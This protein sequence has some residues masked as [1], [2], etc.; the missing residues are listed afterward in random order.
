MVGDWNVVQDYEIDTCNYKSNNNLKAYKKIHDMKES[1]DLVDIWRSLNPDKT[2]YTWRGPGLKQSR[3]DY[4][5]IST[6]F[7]V[8]VKN[9]DIDISYRSDHSPVSLV[10][11][12]YNQKREG[13]PGNLIIV[14][15]MTRTMYLKLRNVS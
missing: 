9:A 8:H 14:Y 11:Q 1:L 5:L 3:L 15:Y 4:F 12:F 6:D 10:L 7:E 2:R 13:V